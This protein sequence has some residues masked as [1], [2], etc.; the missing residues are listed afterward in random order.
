[1][2][3]ILLDCRMPH[4]IVF[5]FEKRGLVPIL[6]P[7]YE[8]FDTPVSSHPDMLAAP[9]NGRLLM[10]RGYYEEHRELFGK[11]NIIATDE[12]TD[13][14]YPSDILLNALEVNGTVYGRDE[15]SK[16]IKE[17]ANRFVKVK[18]GYARCSVL[19]L[20]NGAVTAD[21]TLHRALSND[22]MNVLKITPGH[23]ALDGYDCGFIGGA[24]AVVGDE[25]IFFGDI[26]KHPDGERIIKFV[27]D[28]GY[29]T[30]CASDAPLYD[31][32]GAVIAEA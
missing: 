25:V 26:T 28:C 13:K 11:L 22:G 10:H 15:I 8:K 14:K 9:V 12:K 20:R 23:I 3:Y 4:R 1:M 5:E 31:Y 21:V 17:A 7:P 27:S 19:L 6:L 18:Q 2:K 24:S 32:G 30:V 29:G 16:Y